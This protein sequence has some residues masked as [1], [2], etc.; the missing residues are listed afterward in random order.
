[1]M[2]RVFQPF[3]C[4]FGAGAVI[5]CQPR[6]LA[7]VDAIGRYILMARDNGITTTEMVGTL[8][9]A[10][11]LKAADARQ[12]CRQ[13]NDLMQP[14]TVMDEPVP[15]RSRM[16]PE[17]LSQPMETFIELLGT[18]IAIG[19]NCS[20]SM[21][22]VNA[23]WGPAFQVSPAR[24]Q[25]RG[26]RIEIV[27]EEDHW[28]LLCNGDV[29]ETLPDLPT[30]KSA[31][32]REV[33]CGL[34]NTRD[35]AAVLHAAAVLDGD[36]LLVLAGQSGSGKT[37]LATALIARGATFFSDDCV[38]LRVDTLMACTAPG[39]L[40]L[41]QGALTGLHDSFTGW[42][43]GDLQ[44]MP[45]DLRHYTRPRELASQPEA[46]VSALIFPHFQQGATGQIQRLDASST[47]KQLLAS[48]SG[49]DTLQPQKLASW[50][51][52][53]QTTP[54]WSICYGHTSQGLSYI[55]DILAEHC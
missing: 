9:T 28:Q 44:G 31:L 17:T 24:G 55:D 12:A 18:R 13:I 36:S 47:L 51:N 26:L 10:H 53:I 43:A 38:P 4:V 49:I 46:H 15:A 27:K 6:Q 50:L 29:V 20:D 52:W 35:W 3:W 37:T 7:E 11:G 34:H 23:L 5:A 19:S 8:T 32:M 2:P 41:R 54:A 33:L 48:G 45:G 30:L 25:T 21:K 14:S 40:G 1:M 39:N 16:A 42:L 22:L